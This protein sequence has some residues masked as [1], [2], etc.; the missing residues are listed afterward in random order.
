MD[1]I[2]QVG[3]DIVTRS[4]WNNTVLIQTAD[5]ILVDRIAS[6]PFVLKTRRVWVEPDS[7]PERNSRRK[8]QVKK[9]VEKTGNYYGDA[10]RQIALH[11]GDS[12]HATGFKGKEMEITVIDAGFYNAD[13]IPAFKD[14]DLLETR[15]F[16]NPRSDIYAEHAHGMMVFSC[17][18]ARMPHRIVGTAPEASYWLLRSEDN[19]TEQPVEEDY[20][21]TTGRE[22]GRASCRERV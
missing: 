6:L 12:L 14:I 5:S 22:I 4:K 19:D 3:V 7:V 13:V 9:Q 2:K 21:A 15:D 16:M 17:M 8:E 10:F 11:H 18:A 1:E 20:W